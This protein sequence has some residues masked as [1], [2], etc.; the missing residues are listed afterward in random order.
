MSCITINNS[1]VHKNQA[2]IIQIEGWSTTARHKTG[3]LLANEAPE[4]RQKF[5][6]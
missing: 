6:T 5:M 1:R 4:T 3:E 2:E